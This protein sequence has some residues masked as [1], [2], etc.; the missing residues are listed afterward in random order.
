MLIL[1][2]AVA[3]VSAATVERPVFITHA[4]FKPASWIDWNEGRALPGAMIPKLLFQVGIKMRRSIRVK[5]DTK[6]PL[7]RIVPANVFR[8]TRVLENWKI[9][10]SEEQVHQHLENDICEVSF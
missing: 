9:V 2:T 1:V 7:D 5:V 10:E 4:W 8:Q 3:D 6:P